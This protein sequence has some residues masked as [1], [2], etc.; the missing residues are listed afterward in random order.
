MFCLQI[1]H[2]CIC[3]RFIYS[4][5]QFAYFAAAKYADRSWEER[6]RSQIHD[7]RNWERGFTVSFLRTHKSDFPYSVEKGKGGWNIKSDP[8][9]QTTG[10]ENPLE[11]IRRQDAE[12]RRLLE[13]RGQAPEAKR[14]GHG[15]GS[16][17][18]QLTEV[19]EQTEAAEKRVAALAA[20][21]AARRQFYEANAPPQVRK[22]LPEIFGDVTGPRSEMCESGK[23]EELDD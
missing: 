1:S 19:Q 11:T 6:N 5:D 12:T 13:T 22:Q 4:Q 8:F 14:P 21:L 7:C 16:L 9:A 15:D 18:K 2:S 17:R 20:E 23:I 10:Q 3:E